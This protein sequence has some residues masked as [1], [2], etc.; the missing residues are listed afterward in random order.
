[1]PPATESGSAAPTFPPDAVA[2]FE[3]LV[4]TKCP[5]AWFEN[6]DFDHPDAEDPQTRILL[7]DERL[8]RH[9]RRE[10]RQERAA[11]KKAKAAKKRAQAQ[12]RRAA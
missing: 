12:R 4:S 6:D 10:R 1:M 11:E 3:G 5:E 7:L 2:T 8:R 9:Q